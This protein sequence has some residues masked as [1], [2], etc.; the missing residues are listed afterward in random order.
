MLGL[1]GETVMDTS[2]AAF[3]VSTVDPETPADV[4][5]IVVDP[6]ATVVATPRDPAVM[7]IVAMP[8]LDEV[9]CTSAVKS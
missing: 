2:A 8:V 1:L 9:H 5:V 4:A 3:T 6:A 7:L